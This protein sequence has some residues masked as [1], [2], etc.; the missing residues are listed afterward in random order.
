MK[1]VI[2]IAGKSGSGKTTVAEYIAKEFDIPMVESYTTRPPRFFN[3]PGHMF[4]TDYQ[5]SSLEDKDKIAHTT[6][7][8]YKYCSMLS[9]L[10]EM[11]TYVIDEDG[12]NYMEN[13]FGKEFNIYNIWVE[14]SNTQRLKRLEDSFGMNIA[15]TRYK[16]DINKYGNHKIKYNYIINNDKSMEKLTHH[17][18]K[19]IKDIT[20]KLK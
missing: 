7:G 2:N 20:E 16:R 10:K 11:N 17:I 1:T 6:F 19:V 15:L 3:E 14:A 13:N 18:D 5:F 9:D 12:I 4:I 8:G